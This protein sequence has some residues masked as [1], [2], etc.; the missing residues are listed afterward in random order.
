MEKSLQMC[1]VTGI[2]MLV[3]LCLLV[4]ERVSVE[5]RCGLKGLKIVGRLFVSLFV[6]LVM[7]IF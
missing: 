6:N 2:K 5:L 3:L 1:E 4:L 7:I